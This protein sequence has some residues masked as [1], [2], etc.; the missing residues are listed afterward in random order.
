MEFECPVCLDIIP[1]DEG[2]TYSC[3]C[4]IC[5][6]CFEDVKSSHQEICV[7]CKKEYSLNTSLP[8]G[9]SYNE[10]EIN[11]FLHYMSMYSKLEAVFSIKKNRMDNAKT[12]FDVSYNSVP[13][14]IKKIQ[15][16]YYKEKKYF[17]D[18]QQ[19]MTKINQKALLLI[20]LN[21]IRKLDELNIII[22]DY[23]TRYSL[24][25]PLIELTPTKN[26]YIIYGN[27]LEMKKT[28][29]SLELFIDNEGIEIT[30]Q[31][32][33]FFNKSDKVPK[34]S[35]YFLVYVSD[36]TYSYV[37]NG[38]HI[39][40]IT[41][42]VKKIKY[43]ES[44][45]MAY[46]VYLSTEKLLNLVIFTPEKMSCVIQ[47]ND[48]LDLMSLVLFDNKVFVYDNLGEEFDVDVYNENGLIKKMRCYP[49]EWYKES[50]KRSYIFFDDFYITIWFELYDTDYCGYRRGEIYVEF[51]LYKECL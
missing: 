20:S 28:T 34:K 2:M 35:D 8:I 33:S 18:I 7:Q 6:T 49:E 12:F 46:M 37:Y 36:S 21:Y 41:N 48:R 14:P 15:E 10:I 26:G 5:K 44:N 27:R 32:V 16:L 51:L 43:K 19:I 9:P 4:Y 24:N 13:F 22:L 42:C 30:S 25:F 29:N 1:Y 38:T 50:Y 39:H 23:L 31:N 3:L 40:T 11:T 17:E 47:N 45:S